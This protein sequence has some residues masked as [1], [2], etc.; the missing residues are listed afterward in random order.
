ME[1][2]VII[3]GM[4]TGCKTAARLRRL[5]P[6][7]S[8]TILEKL[9]FVSFSTCGMPFFA[10]GDIDDFNDLIKTPW[11]KPRD[12]EFF[13]SAKDIDVLTQS[14][15]T[16][17]DFQ[18]KTV[19][20]KSLT[21]SEYKTIEFD[22]L[23]IAT[24][25]KPIEP[26]FEFPSSEKIMNFHSP[27]D[28]KKVRLMAQKGE[29][30]KAVIIGGGYIGCELAEALVSL[31]GIDTTIIEKE[32]HLLPMSLDKELGDFLTNIFRNHSVKI[33]ANTTVRMITE[34][35]EGHFDIFLDNDEVLTSD[36]VFLC[37]GVKP[38]VEL[39]EKSGLETGNFGGIKVDNQLR[40]NVSNVWA[41]GDCIEIKNLITG[42]YG[43]YP[44][45]SLANRQGRVIADS[46]AGLESLFPGSVGA[47]S[48]KVFDTIIAGSG[49]NINQAIAN[50]FNT[51]KVVGAWYD[52]PDYHPDAK[53][54]FGKLIYEKE[55]LRLLGIQMIGKGEV[56]R[57][58]DTFTS[59]LSKNG[60]LY[61]LI[62]AEHCYTPPHSAPMNPL[63]FLGAMALEQE[64]SGV[65]NYS[66][67]E[68]PDD[69]IIIDLREKE[70]VE[71]VPLSLDS[72]NLSFDEYRKHI[73]NFPKD[74]TYIFVCQK[75]PRSYE[76]AF[77]LKKLGFENIGYLGGG[78][79]LLSKI[80]D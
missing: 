80:I 56:T 9:P 47:I 59:L 24:G 37:T 5:R 20:F 12:T 73:R 79:Q 54:I 3:G 49:L 17:I 61:D 31:W 70:E 36:T 4:A 21:S 2:V 60:N 28:A 6:D 40:T 68:I 63:N 29:I 43:Y 77:F 58:T 75:G 69:A 22:K 33:S 46:I 78:M 62:N 18:K 57:Y 44:L 11:G 50:A 15:V 23:V 64:N 8:I 32:S 55:S 38:S 14:E 74:K 1:K 30:S 19:S 72:Q 65:I 39:F 13:K 52:R 41:G 35:E 51:A 42:N 71:S 27:I 16:K 67:D 53:P 25:A 45:G 76:G 48:I 10:S 34:T 26:K 7:F 66:F